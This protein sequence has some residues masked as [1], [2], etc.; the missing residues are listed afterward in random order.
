MY[1]TTSNNSFT[2]D[3]PTPRQNRDVR[4]SIKGTSTPHS[5]FREEYGCLCEELGTVT[6]TEGESQA[7]HMTDGQYTGG[8][9]QKEVEK[10][11]IF[12]RDF[13]APGG[14]GRH[15][16]ERLKGHSSLCYDDSR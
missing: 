9:L 6:G 12:A 2:V 4:K 13:V 15:L 11:K 8:H 5:G 7:R 1:L 10:R 3:Q 16:H 14:L